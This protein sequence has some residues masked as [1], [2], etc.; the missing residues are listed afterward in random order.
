MGGSNK[1]DESKNMLVQQ[2]IKPCFPDVYFPNAVTTYSLPV[3][4]I[5]QSVV[6]LISSSH[7]GTG[8][9]SETVWHS[10]QLVIARGILKPYL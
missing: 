5:V 7:N 9:Q 4:S 1:W 6:Q 3:L 10:H 2:H 8:L